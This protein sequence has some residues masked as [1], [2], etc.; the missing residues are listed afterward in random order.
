MLLCC[1]DES[2]TFSGHLSPLSLAKLPSSCGYTIRSTQSSLVL[3]APYDGCFVIME[4]GFLWSEHSA[5]LTSASIRV[6]VCLWLQ[7]NSYV[8]PLRW[9]GLPVKMSCPVVEQ[10]SSNPPMV[11]CH[12]EGMVVRTE[13]TNSASDIKANGEFFSSVL[14]KA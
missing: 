13:W 12:A 10:V 3:V 6:H 1:A 7:E 5:D 8:L 14:S 4:V 9:W 11:T 2:L